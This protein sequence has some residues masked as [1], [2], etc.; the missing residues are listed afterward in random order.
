M[1]DATEKDLLDKAYRKSSL[2]YYFCKNG[3]A[4]NYDEADEIVIL[5]FILIQNLI[6]FR[7]YFPSEPTSEPLR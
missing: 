2:R 3:C 6:H 5:N 4:S 7:K 1:G